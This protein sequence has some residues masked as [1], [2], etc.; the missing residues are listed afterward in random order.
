VRLARAG[1]RLR[2]TLLAAA[3]LI[4]AGEGPAS[5][6]DV[7]AE[8]SPPPASFENGGRHRSEN[9]GRHRSGETDPKRADRWAGLHVFEDCNR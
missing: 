1:R 3:L 9:G 2:R 5:A 6:T 8:K 4:V 7:E